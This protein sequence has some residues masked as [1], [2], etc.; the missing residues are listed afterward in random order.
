LPHILHLERAG[1]YRYKL[2]YIFIYIL[3]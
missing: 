1:F 3:T 2:E